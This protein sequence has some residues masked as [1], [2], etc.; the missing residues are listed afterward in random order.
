MP[1]RKAAKK[2]APVKASAT[3]TVSEGAHRALLARYKSATDEL[4]AYRH[5]AKLHAPWL[6]SAVARELAAAK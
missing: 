4:D 3:P 1:T 5:L 2:A 6:V